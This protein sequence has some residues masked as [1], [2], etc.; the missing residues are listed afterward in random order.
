MGKIIT[1]IFLL[2]LGAIAY[3]AIFN[4]DP[5]TIVITE[6]IFYEIPKM[7][8]VLISAISGALLMLLVYSIRDTRRF[9]NNIQTQKRQKK[10]QRVQQLYSRALSAIYAG[11]AEIAIDALN[12]ILT[13]DPGNIH[14]I[15]RLGEIRLKNGE[16]K[17]AH[18]HFKKA[19]TADPENTETLLN[20]VKVKEAQGALEDALSYT[21]DILKADHNNLTAIYKR[22]ELLEK[23]KRW[24]ELVSLQKELIKSAPTE[25]ARVSE[26]RTLTGYKYESGRESLEMGELEKARKTF[27]TV[28]RL[29]RDFIPAHLGLTEVMIQEG[30]TAD[31]INYLEKV[32]HQSRSMIL[33]ARLEDLLLNLGEPSRLIAIYKKALTETATDNVLRFFLVKLYYRLEMLDDALEA[34]NEIEN[35]SVF[36]E[37]ASIKGDIFFKRGQYQNASSEFKSAL[38]MRQSLRIQYCCLNCSHLSKKWSGR[39]PS[40]GVWNSFYYN[41]YGACRLEGEGEQA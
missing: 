21:D 18:D 14:A 6:G 31:A 19:L 1:L 5:V 24:D 32:Y 30:S 29:D 28:V 11:K 23:L 12:E 40:C 35:P 39:C 13:I 26:Q 27:R 37:I 10:Q 2:F 36:P 15:L 41:V 4:R 34:I 7:A 8:L 22:R 9:I 17:K 38:N 3:L 25:E 16:L 33:L 20:L